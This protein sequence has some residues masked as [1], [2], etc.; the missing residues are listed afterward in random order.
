MNPDYLTEFEENG[1]CGP[2]ELSDSGAVDLLLSSVLAQHE[3]VPARESVQAKHV[4]GEHKEKPLLLANAHIENDH[5]MKTGNDDAILDRLAALMGDEIYLRRSQFWRKPSGSRGVMWHQDKHEKKG[6]GEIGEVSAWV[7][8]EDSTIDNGC[9]WLLKGSH[10]MGLVP[11][12]SMIDTSFLIK[13]FASNK[14][15][16]PDTFDGYEVVPMEVKKGQFFIFHQMCFHA[17]GPNTSQGTRTGVVY[18]Y[19]TNGDFDGTT[20]TL[21]R[22]V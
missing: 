1:F 3:F 6:L 2:F 4:L 14:L 11:P 16:V 7:A 13:F 20:E 22:V 8:L 5:V 10:K 17:S 9:V 19:L 15:E 21:T 18:R 12:K